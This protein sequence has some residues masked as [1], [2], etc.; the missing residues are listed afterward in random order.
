M[1][2][3]LESF[4]ATNKDVKA[5]ILPTFNHALGSTTLLLLAIYDGPD[6]GTVFD[7]F[8][9]I[10]HLIDMWKAQ[11][12]SDYV[13]G[14][15]SSLQGNQRGLFHSVSLQEFSKELLHTIINHTTTFGSI[16]GHP[17]NTIS[18]DVEPFV[19]SYGLQANKHGPTM[20][21]HS[22]SPLPLNLYWSWSSSNDDSYFKQAALDSV[23][24]IRAQAIAEGQQ[25]DNFFLY[26][27]YCLAE[28]P[29]VQM[30]GTANAAFL[31]ATKQKYDPNN[32]MGQT[33]YFSFAT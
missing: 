20:F 21:P 6:P 17:S 33:T 28:T 3:T 31:R 25:L 18:F 7:P 4:S 10:P 5:Q 2:D 13:S 30:Y 32:I 1:A 8:N 9:A 11:S 12:Y 22:N 14:V 15:P 29:A 24:I 27:N 23:A 19:K 26:P 16:P